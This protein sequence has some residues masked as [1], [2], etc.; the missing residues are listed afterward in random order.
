VKEGYRRVVIRTKG[1]GDFNSL[2]AE[3]EGVFKSC[4][5]RKG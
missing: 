3:I 1:R 4:Q 2:Q 5:I